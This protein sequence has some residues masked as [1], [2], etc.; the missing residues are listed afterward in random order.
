MIQD[1]IG[2]YDAVQALPVHSDIP[3][4]VKII[5]DFAGRLS[6]LAS[7]FLLLKQAMGP[8][9]SLLRNP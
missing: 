7:A 9:L 4:A 1:T 5:L 6:P 3:D 2:M 8:A